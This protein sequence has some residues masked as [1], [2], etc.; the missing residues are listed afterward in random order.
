[1]RTSKPVLDVVISTGGRFD[2]LERCI[3]AIYSTAT[4]PLTITIVDDAT[5]KEKRSHYLYLF[6]YDKTKDTHS[7][8]V[9]INL[10]RNEKTQGYSVSNNIGAKVGNAP[11][12]VFMND[13]V[14]VFPDYFEKLVEVM[15]D[16]AIGV[17]G[18]KLIFPPTSTDRHR[19]AGKVQHIGLALDIRANAVHPLNGWSPT[20]PKTNFKRSCLAVT[21]A[22]LATR[23]DVFNK[24]GGFDPI[25]GRGYWEDVDLC[26]KVRALGGKIWMDT[27]LLAYHYTGASMEIDPTHGADFQKN[28]LIFR[29]KWQST[30]M[31]RYDSWSY[32]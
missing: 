7:N 24:V 28:T 4:V 9:R 21:G 22:L 25:Y 2:M 3:N 18:A 27:S 31:L 32:G 14:E 15:E 12:I 19:P 23:R 17:C 26:L 1:M 8:V 10:K 16:K 6:D 13:D 29:S 11:L 5:D 20:N 30:G